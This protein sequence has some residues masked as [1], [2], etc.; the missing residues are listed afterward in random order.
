MNALLSLLIA[1]LLGSVPSAYY[2]GKWV[3]GIDLRECGSGNL[4][5]TNAWR[6][7]GALWSLPVLVFDISKGC[8]AV[9]LAKW[10]VP[11]NDYMAITAGMVA[12]LGHNWTIFLG[13]KGGGK[14]VACSAGVFLALMPAPFFV[15]LVVFIAVLFTT[16]IMSIASITGATTLVAC[17]AVLRGLHW[18]S[19]PSTAIYIFSILVAVMIIA[20]H[21][22]NIER[23][24]QG[25]EPTLGPKKEE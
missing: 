23:L 14:G 13:F 2:A 10:L 17:G 16:R 6:N 4:G 21:K 25:T 20:K 18:P 22:S 9:Y 7:L 5:F 11:G 24:M 19:A 3:K 8:V 12:I 15:T 1:Y